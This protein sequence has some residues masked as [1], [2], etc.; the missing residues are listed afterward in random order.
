MLERGREVSA[1]VPPNATL[2]DALE[3]LLL[4][5][6]GQACVVDERG[7][8]QGIL[9]ISTLT[10]VLRRMRADAKKH[11]DQLTGSAS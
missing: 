10:D 1:K 7:A 6:A 11:Y 9:D 3:E 4:S 8:F 2:H 5:N